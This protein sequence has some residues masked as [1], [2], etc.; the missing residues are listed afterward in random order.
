MKIA[1][2]GAGAI[3]CFFGG[4]LERKDMDVTFVAKG[5]TLERLRQH[6]LIVKSIRGDFSL[7]VK[8]VDAEQLR[9]EEN[10][11]FILL[12]IKSTA[13]DDVIPKL[14]TL[15]GP[16]TEIV[17]LLNGIGNEERLAEIFGDDR[18]VGGSAFISII[19]EAPGIVNHVGEGTLMI[20]E[21]KK[22][23]SSKSLEHLVKVFHESG[24]RTE[25]S[26]DI[27]QV[28][29]E[30]LLWNIIYNP[31]TALT[32]TRVGEALD[33]PDLAYLLSQVKSEF[34]S[35]ADAAGVSISTDYTSK[36]LLP[37]PEVQNHKT[38]MLQD[39]ESGREMELEAILGFVIKTADQYKVP[40]KTIETIYHLLRF[41]ERK[42]G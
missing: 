37:N 20:G 29:W 33:D 24:I 23:K 40:V 42:Q 19:R 39:L 14:R 28:K 7:P 34:L 27:R 6:D 9:A 5:R 3:G 15:S 30:K 17:C 1:V 2:L 38:S 26:A 10:Y 4:L 31:L 21:W 25:I 22:G 36:V 13:L 18:V 12:A 35:T 16:K 32:G 8:V 11:D 41:T